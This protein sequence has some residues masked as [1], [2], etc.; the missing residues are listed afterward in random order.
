MTFHT[1]HQISCDRTLSPKRSFGFRYLNFSRTKACRRV[2]IRS[3]VCLCA[4]ATSSHTGTE[5]GST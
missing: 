2:F 5:V 1:H 4:P 3:P